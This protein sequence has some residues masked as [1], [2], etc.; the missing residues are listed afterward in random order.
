MVKSVFDL[1]MTP[2]RMLPLIINVSQ[3]DDIGRTIV[4]NLYSSVGAWTA[5]TS[6]AVTFEGGKPDGK[7]FSYNCAYSNGTVTVTIQQQMTAVAGKVRCKVK[8]KSGDKVVES[9]PIIMIVDAAAV[10]DGSDMSKTDINDAIANATQKIV[11][12]VKDNIPSDYAQLSTDVSSLKED[13]VD[14][15]SISDDGKIPR[16]KEGGVEWVEVGQ[17]TDE[18]TDSAVTKWLDKHPEATTTVQDGVITVKKLET[19]FLNMIGYP[20]F[21]IFPSESII[22]ILGNGAIFCTRGFYKK[23]DNGESC[24]IIHNRSYLNC[25]K[26]ND[27][28]YV[29]PLGNKED[30]IYAN[31]YGI[32]PGRSATENT[33]A[34]NKIHIVFGTL[35]KF[36]G[37]HYYFK[38]PLNLSD[39]QV[40]IIGEIEMGRD[41]KNKAGGTWLHFENLNNG[42]TAVTIRASTIANVSIVGSTSNYNLSINRDNV[43]DNQD[44]IV[45]ET[46]INNTCGLKLLSGCK[47][48]GINVRNYYTGIN[49]SGGNSSVND[50]VI[51]NAHSGIICGNDN[52]LAN[53]NVTNVMIGVEAR[54]SLNSVNSI[55]GDSIGLHLILAVSSNLTIIDAD[56]DFCVGALISI[57]DAN[58]H[59]NNVSGLNIYGLRGRCN[60]KH[61][62]QKDSTPPS[63]DEITDDN[64]YEYPIIVVNRHTNLLGANIQLNSSGEKPILD[65]NFDY[66]TPAFLLCCASTTNVTNVKI[67]VGNNM[68]FY[69]NSNDEVRIDK[70]YC[71]ARI[72]SLS[73]NKNSLLVSVEN[74][75]DKVIIRKNSTTY[76]YS[77]VSTETID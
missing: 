1:D 77:K 3:Y 74:Y 38:D 76:Y 51:N 37:G 27:S 5:P 57:G 73:H 2:G 33:E 50:V 25:I 63:L 53:I 8:V 72:K 29:T 55:R 70:N 41:D 43:I 39:L 48:N 28:L 18:Q 49:I 60:A 66:M 6:A 12:Q 30:M 16:A 26:I 9:A 21:D 10:P 11:E 67:L 56:G 35:L 69:N 22:N 42:Q 14:K 68:G 40:S 47:V 45:T 34:F 58:D 32:L 71:E 36:S 17:P 15:P 46:C 64:L 59:W 31:H 61:A 24:Y 75:A 62:Y 13:K 23:N 65:D 54:G 52:K 44:N 19:T 4:F 7:F 20:I